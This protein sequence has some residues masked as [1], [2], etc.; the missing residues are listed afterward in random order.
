LENSIFGKY[1]KKKPI[2]HT[3]KRI[4]KDHKFLKLLVTKSGY[5]A[6][7]PDNAMEKSILTVPLGWTNEN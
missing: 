4:V 5:T 3:P 6:L 7:N 1:D 2:V